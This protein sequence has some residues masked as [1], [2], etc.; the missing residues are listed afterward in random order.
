MGTSVFKVIYLHDLFDSR[1]IYYLS[2]LE[3]HIHPV[4][5]ALFSRDIFGDANTRPGA[6]GFALRISRQISLTQI[7]LTH[8]C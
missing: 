2:L 8:L 1:G 7:S 6:G 4:A 3:F 5:L